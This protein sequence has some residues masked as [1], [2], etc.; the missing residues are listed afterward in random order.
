MTAAVSRGLSGQHH[1]ATGIHLGFAFSMV[2]SATRRL[3]STVR[4]F[5][6]SAIID[7]MNDAERKPICEMRVLAFDSMGPGE[8]WRRDW[9]MSKN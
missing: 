6:G 5:M 2:S 3:R 7:A 8:R 4:K 1:R 9:I